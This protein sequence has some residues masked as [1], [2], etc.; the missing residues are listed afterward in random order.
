VDVQV[1]VDVDGFYDITDNPDPD[2]V[3]LISHE[4]SNPTDETH[5]T[6]RI[7]AKR[8]TTNTD[9]VAQDVSLHDH[10]GNEY[11]VLNPMPVNVVSTPATNENIKTMFDEAPAVASGSETLIISYSVPIGKIALLQR[12]TFSG[13]NVATYNLYINGSIEERKRTHFGADL[14]GEMVFLGGGEEGPKYVPGDTIEL[15]VLH[16][17]PNPGSFNGRI[18]VMELG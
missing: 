3:G 10:L 9:V 11:S 8:G 4:R 14:S 16:T 13:E 7:T 1:D 6:Q 17:R 12:I 5:Q 18:Q 15:K 2:N